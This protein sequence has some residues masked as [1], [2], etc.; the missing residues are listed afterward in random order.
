MSDER[1]QVVIV[2]GSLVGLS[3]ALFLRHH[4]VDVVLVE[5]HPSTSIQPRTPGYN[6]R[7]MELF[8][9][10]G[11]E[12]E[13]RAAGPWTLT[14]SGIL[15]AES[16][17]SPNWH[18]IE[19][20]SMHAPTEGF[21]EVSPSEM[22]VLSQDEL[23]PVLRARAESLGGDLRFATEL[24]SFD[25]DDEGVAAEVSDR[26]TGVRSS[27]RADFLIA[28]D[29]ADS[30][31]REELGIG[32]DGVGVLGHQVGIMGRA[33]LSE[34]LDGRSFA[35]SMVENRHVSGMVRV[36]GDLMILN[37]EYDPDQ[38]AVSEQFPEHRCVELVRAAAGVPELPVEFLDVQPWTMRAAVAR[39]FAEGRVFLAGD[40][41]HVMPPSGALGANTGVQ[42]G[43]NLAWKLAFVLGGRA[44]SALLDTYDAERRPVAELTVD[45]ALARGGAWFG[46]D[47][48]ASVELVDDLTLMF[49]YR[50]DSAAVLAETGDRAGVE[51]PRRPSWA[52]GTRVPHVW[53]D[54]A[55]GKSTVD[56]CAS[57]LVLLAGTDDEAWLRASKEL[58]ERFGVTLS[59][60]RVDPTGW[61]SWELGPSGVVLLRPDGFI[62]WRCTTVPD[63]PADTLEVVSGR[64]LRR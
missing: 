37:V 23:E 4:G 20:P 28:A 39:R 54:E 52:P 58:G 42:D 18:W 41:A 59:V 11:V 30:P 36:V 32:R 6:A 50:Y 31:V 15:W 53:L 27:V 26:R 40:A 45:Q 12:D 8:R 47:E 22:A 51:D 9:A 17:N 46:D 13:V 25:P 33:D 2:G 43:W 60:H 61:P 16:L 49:G 29:G 55:Q 34:L 62:A 1:T 35:I 24:V 57:G 44:G 63:N 7:T 3:T 38:G 10:V 56:V 19:H 21:S 5:R 48:A 14:G 64:V